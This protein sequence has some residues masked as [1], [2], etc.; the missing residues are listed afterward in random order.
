MGT[1]DSRRTLVTC[2]H[3]VG[4]VAVVF[5][6]VVAVLLTVGVIQ[7]RQADPLE[8]PG[9]QALRSDVAAAP[10]DEALRAEVRELDRL[11]RGAYFGGR[12]YLKRGGR[13]LAGGGIVLLLALGGA[14]WL[15]RDERLRVPRRAAESPD[16][17]GVRGRRAVTLVL[18]GGMV[19]AFVLASRHGVRPAALS[20]AAADGAKVSPEP[21]PE[22]RVPA[23]PSAPWPGLRG[24]GGLGVALPDASVPTSIVWKVKVPRKGYSS[25]VIDGEQVYVT[26]GDADGI[27][28]YAFGLADGDLRWSVVLEEDLSDVEAFDDFMYAA[29]TPAS[30]GRLIVAISPL[31][32]VL[33]CDATGTKVWERD[34]GPVDNPYGHASSLL[35]QG[36]HVIVQLDQAGAPELIALQR[37]TGVVAWRTE[38]ED[39]SWSSPVAGRFGG[40]T[41]LVV[42][43]AVDVAA[44]APESGELRWRQDYQAGEIGSSVSLV[45]DFAV[46][47]S[48][49]A[50]VIGL[51]PDGSGVRVVWHWDEGGSSMA[52]PII[53]ED[54]VVV[55]SDDGML[56]CLEAA[57]GDVVWEE[58]LDNGLYA[59]PL[60]VG[61]DLLL[62]DL[63]G[64]LLTLSVGRE[65]EITPGVALGE[66]VHATPALAGRRL[67]VR[68]ESHLFCLE[69]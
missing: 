36:P 49:D 62:V 56:V 1:T 10:R 50:G 19:L 27:E 28:L 2:C 44:Y 20:P 14:R 55:G 37:D 33:A 61:S 30:D 41:Q 3:W 68:G 46:A 26:G 24:A 66:A 25:P 54:L 58:F 21:R 53:A 6:L 57:S 16:R 64:N 48:A 34:L 13:L 67:V 22:V 38:R 43:S 52:S 15:Q 29:S 9:L 65:F 51:R 45:D 35:V 63:E 23:P 42:I 17:D 69:D 4:G 7:L 12:Q 59:S 47:S 8:S 18:I 39:L 11:A 31:G 40:A 32:R 60:L 5:C